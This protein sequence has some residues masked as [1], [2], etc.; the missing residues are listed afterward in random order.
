MRI[1]SGSTDQGGSLSASVH[2]VRQGA[3]D[4]PA[5]GQ[6]RGPAALHKLAIAALDSTADGLVILD[7]DWRLVF[8]NAAAE[9]LIRRSRAEVVG[10]LLEP[11]F[12]GGWD[13]RFGVEFRRAKA[14]NVPVSF[15]EFYPEPLNAW[16]EVR[17]YPSPDGFSIV[18]RD[19]TERRQHEE[20]L[21]AALREEASARARLEAV[22]DALPTGVAI[23]DAGGAIVRSNAAF[24][25]AWGIGDAAAL[26]AH[27]YRPPR[28]RWNDTGREVEPDEWASVRARTR[29]ETVPAQ[30]VEVERFDGRLAHVL[31]AAAPIVDADGAVTGC[32]VVVQD[33]SERIGA[34]RALARSEDA[35]R[36]AN[37]ELSSVNRAL[38]QNNETLEAR[39]VQ[40]T[41]DLAQR[42]AQLQAL[43][44]DLTKAEEL[45][46]RKV[47]EV[48]HDQLQQILSLARIKLGLARGR[49]ADGPMLDDL[50][51]ADELIAE[52]LDITRSLTAEL[53][54]AI[55]H[56]SGLANT[57]RWLG[58]W[59]EDRFG[60]RVDVDAAD[61]PDTDEETR[62]TLFRSARELLFNVV[63]HA[64]VARARIQLSRTAD[65]RACIVVSDEGAGFNPEVLRAWD[66]AQGGFGLFSLR[67]RL[68][69]LGGRFDADSA[70]GRGARFTIIGPPP[71][72]A[73]AVPEPPS[74]APAAVAVTRRTV[75]RSASGRGRKRL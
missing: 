2:A 47:A 62:V 40:R 4:R 50:T 57:L 13:S 45:E 70:P 68:D 18:F 41:T 59:Y 32:V 56:R 37:D 8:M 6:P 27:D 20:K 39:V 71:G 53:R 67:E 28:G 61:D 26:P 9:R 55:L 69:Q 36:C 31:N 10:K 5:S 35:L 72:P 19:V 43:A 60:L 63:K 42:T 46:R 11:F 29:G 16:F 44:R 23:L 34:E 24:G 54:P 14:E 12:P 17:A 75:R 64:G 33:I 22:M 25:Q 38:R 30:A 21:A 15:E 1:E 66:G 48:I 51:D 3:A 58:R 52:S 74:A 7:D 49:T 65:G 73:P